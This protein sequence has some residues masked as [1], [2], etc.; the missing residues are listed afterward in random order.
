MLRGMSPKLPVPRASI[1]WKLVGFFLVFGLAVSGFILVSGIRTT[2]GAT[3]RMLQRIARNAFVDEFPDRSASLFRRLSDGT[4]ESLDRL[5]SHFP[6]VHEPPGDFRMILYGKEPRGGWMEFVE[7]ADGIRG[8]RV[9]DGRTVRYLRQAVLGEG[10][11]PMDPFSLPGNPIGAAF[12]LPGGS[13]GTQWVLRLQV[14]TAGILQFLTDNEAEVL[15]FLAALSALALGLGW[16]FAGRFVRPL[17]DLASSAEGYGRG[18]VLPSAFESPRRDEIGV[19]G[20]TL[21]DMARQLE[22]AKE[23]LEERLAA[24]ESMNAID[25]AVLSGGPREDLLSR[26]TAVIAGAADARSV[27]LAVRDPDRR[28]WTLESLASRDGTHP[29]RAPGPAPFLSEDLLDAAA[30]GFFDRECL[31]SLADADASLRSLVYDITEA[32][33]GWLVNEPLIVD[34]RYLGSLVVI[35]DGKEPPSEEARRVLAL[36]ADQAAVALRSVL[37]REAREDNFVG[38][39]RSLTRAID[40]KSRWTAGHSERVADLA[41]RLGTALGQPREALDRLRIAALLHDAGKIG[42][43]E[44]VLDK[45]G[46]LSPGE[47]EEI[48]RHPTVG[49]DLL[50]GIRSFGPVVPGVRHHHERWD[51]S[52]YPDGLAGPAIPEDARILAVADVWDAVTADRP[53]RSRMPRPE[54]RAFMVRNSGAMFEPRLVEAFLSLLAEDDGPA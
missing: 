21:A 45:P 26:V 43:R 47:F 16:F 34:S 10:F 19:L 38:V 53:Y 49:A 7:D 3:L 11:V 52:G 5:R 31:L 32:E 13:D 33:I 2:A 4:G 1:R 50:E 54:A 44:A 48:R 30:C 22:A 23:S 20:R 37:E 51:G 25:R 24:K 14:P 42:V 40:A 29:C 6:T 8:V 36:L 15:Q 12:P 28:G 39:I 18:T 27:F 17:A 35:A 46:A 9:P 41:V